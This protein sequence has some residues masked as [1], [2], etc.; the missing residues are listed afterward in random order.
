MFGS[1]AT[2]AS[3][4]VLDKGIVETFSGM[5]YSPSEK[6]PPSPDSVLHSNSY[7]KW[8]NNNSHLKSVLRPSKVRQKAKGPFTTFPLKS[9]SPAKRGEKKMESLGSGK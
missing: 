7:S 5:D 2:A 4:A 8:E 1:L 9:I 3:W 6:R